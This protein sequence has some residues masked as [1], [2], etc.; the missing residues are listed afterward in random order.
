MTVKQRVSLN[1][2]EKKRNKK[3]LRMVLFTRLERDIIY[4]TDIFMSPMLYRCL[5]DSS[6]RGN[7][8]E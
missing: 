7:Q 2:L 5:L 8:E 6:I 4:S 1:F 3:R